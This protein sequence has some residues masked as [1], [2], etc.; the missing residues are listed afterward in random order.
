VTKSAQNLL[1]ISAHPDDEVLGC[2]GTVRRLV[3][4]GWKAQ[5]VV[6]SAGIAGRFESARA[7]QLPVKENQIKLRRELE[8][9]AAVTGYCNV[10]TMDFPDNRLD[11]VSRMDLV[12]RLRPVLESFRPQIVFTQ[13]PGDYNWDHERTF[14]AVMMA[15]RPNPPDFSPDEIRTF[16][17]LS[18][19]ERAAQ[20]PHR[21]FCPNLY[22]NVSSTIDVKKL[23]MSYYATEY[24]DY[25]HPRSREAIEYLARKR[26]SEVGLHYAEAFHVVRKIEA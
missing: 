20:E 4:Q 19:T 2:A 8:Q 9:A 14:D 6:L 21:V 23:A 11:T 15:A 1:V 5:L 24:R 22:V 12:H 25:P 10:I 3:N 7:E 17:V 13:H 16:E 18:S 26:G